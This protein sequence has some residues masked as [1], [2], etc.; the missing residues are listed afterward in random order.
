M[1]RLPFY[2]FF[3]LSVCLSTFYSCQKLEPEVEKRYE[4]VMA[5]HDE[6]MPRMSD[7][8]RL[9]KRLSK[10]DTAQLTDMSPNILLDHSLKLEKADNAMMDWMANF[11]KPKKDMPEDIAI[12]YLYEEKK[13]ITAVR[14][15]ML[16][17]IKEA[18]ALLAKVE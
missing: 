8:H 16:E 9:K 14:D 15:L 7:I 5:I 1:Q 2:L 12:A 4:E 18:E 17:S 6:V 11:K 3:I 10:V 13:A